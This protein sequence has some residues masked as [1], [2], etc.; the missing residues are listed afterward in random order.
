MLR[1]LNEVMNDISRESKHQRV[2]TVTHGVSEVKCG[3]G[4]LTPMTQQWCR[5]FP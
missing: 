3:F 2:V 1:M 5:A 4:R